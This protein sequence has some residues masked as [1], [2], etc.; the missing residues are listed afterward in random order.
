MGKAYIFFKTSKVHLFHLLSQLKPVLSSPWS[1]LISEGM[2]PSSWLLLRN[3]AGQGVAGVFVSRNAA[4][5]HQ[6]S[7]KESAGDLLAQEL[8]KH[9]SWRLLRVAFLGKKSLLQSLYCRVALLDGSSEVFLGPLY[10][11]PL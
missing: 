5:N 9:S 3:L 8:F 2:G 4:T 6:P 10:P 11:E 1:R 7:R